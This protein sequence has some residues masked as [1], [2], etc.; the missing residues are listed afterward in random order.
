MKGLSKVTLN[1]ETL[2]ITMLYRDLTLYAYINQDVAALKRY[3]SYG[4]DFNLIYT[5]G[6]P[7]LHVAIAL[8]KPISVEALVGAPYLPESDCTM[9]ASVS[10]SMALRS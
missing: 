7:L 2:E 1:L 9:S 3:K 10:P 4:V 6:A 8:D 5:S